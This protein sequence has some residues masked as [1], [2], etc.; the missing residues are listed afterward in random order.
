MVTTLA[1]VWML[2]WPLD[3]RLL[4]VE[5]ARGSPEPLVEALADPD[6]ARQTIRALGRF[7][8]PELARHVLPFLE[9]D[10]A[11]LRIEAANALA[12][13]NTTE[14]L[15]PY[16]AEERD[17]EVRAALYEALGR[18]EEGA[19][20]LLL[21]GFAETPPARRGAV[22]GLE[23]L[24]RTRD[25]TPSPRAIEALREAAAGS[26]D[27]HTVELALLALLRAGDRHGPT[28]AKALE[29]DEPGVRRLAVQGLDAGHDDLSPRVRYE[30]LRS[31]PSCARAEAAL[32]DA[33][34]HVA[35]LAVDL[36]GDGCS[37]EKLE[38]VVTDKDGW[39]RPAHALVS[40]AQVAPASARPH[41]ERFRSHPVFQARVYAARAAKLLEADETLE[42]L[43]RD[44]HPN[45]VAEALVTPEQA[46]DALDSDHYG[47]LVGALN[48]L[49]ET[50]LPSSATPR[51]LATLERLSAER[52]H[53][54]RDPRRMLLE[55]LRKL[56]SEELGAEL[57]YLLSD[58]DPFIAA[59]AAEIVSEVASRSVAAKTTRFAPEPLP[60]K[61]FIEALH[62]A[63][64]RIEMKEAGTFVIELLPE[65]APLTVARF[66]RLADGGY[67][68]GL[69]FHRVVPGFVIQGGS[70]GANEFV[71]TPGY[72]RDE[73][74]TLSHLRGT[75][76]ISTRGR[77][78]GDSQIFV[79]LE[80][81]FRLDHNYTVFGRVVEGME[82]VDRVL[83]GDV[84]E[85]AEILRD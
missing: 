78:T 56:G 29:K 68:D 54:S 26:S 38:E 30:A 2:Q 16:L 77:D 4:E 71:G 57:D 6:T 19:E 10:E 62:G 44:D 28:L 75:L 31:S 82:A 35:I 39:R 5:D 37:A 58:F 42:I 61:S 55:L 1:L 50:E 8:R 70:P 18:L 51:L 9:A 17:P 22:K 52:K 41:L 24:L 67:Y 76:G 65:V 74:S 12:Q 11:D 46:L 47:L 81:N 49:E 48:L 27:P 15:V 25:Q 79:N 73:V 85:K 53:T 13:M 64:A 59:L 32:D 84:M 69:T 80:D 14:S 66:A 40:L 3:Y 83:E 63:R 45:V 36:L 20:A 23:N 21:P 34:G 33:S 7:E 43:R 72:L 60:E